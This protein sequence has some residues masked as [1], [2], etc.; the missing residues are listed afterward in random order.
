MAIKKLEDFN[1]ILKTAKKNWRTFLQQKYRNELAW[2][3]KDERKLKHWNNI[4]K[5]H[6]EKE[7]IS[8]S[9][10]LRG[11]N[12]EKKYSW[13]IKWCK[14]ITYV[15]WSMIFKGFSL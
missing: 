1:F 10:I 7:K 8:K 12:K 2:D 14:T 9:M 11:S 5:V 6:L 13:M 4:A 3:L 15:N